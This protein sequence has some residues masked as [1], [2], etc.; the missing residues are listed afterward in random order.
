MKLNYGFNFNDLYSVSG[1]NRLDSKFLEYLKLNDPAAYDL[2]T[3]SRQTNITLIGDSLIKCAKILD[4]FIE[5]L[6]NINN[7]YKLQKNTILDYNKQYIVKRQ[8]IQRYALNKYTESSLTQFDY[9][10]ITKRLEQY[11]KNLS[12]FSTEQIDEVYSKAV[13]NWLKDEENN[14]DNLELA[15]IYAAF[16]IYNNYKSLLFS[17]P[18]KT[19]YDSL[20]EL[21]KN[22]FYIDG[23]NKS[24]I[25]NGI[26][27]N[28]DVISFKKSI[29]QSNYCITCHSN[30]KDTC[31]IG[32]KIGEEYKTNPIGNLLL[33]CPLEQKISEMI[34]LYRDTFIIGSLAVIT[35][36]NPLVAATGERIC[37]DCSKSCILH[38]RESVDVP[39]IETQ[40]LKSILGLDYGFEIYSLLTRWIP[41]AGANFIPSEINKY[42]ILV[43]GS[44]PSG[45]AGSLYLLNKG[46]NISMIE[47]LKVSDLHEDLLSKPIK[48]YNTLI[49]A[50]DNR[51][52]QGFGGVA[53]YGI[54]NRWD[55]TMLIVLRLILQRRSNFELIG[56]TRFGSNIT[57]EQSLNTV[58]FDHILLCA[59]SGKP[60]IPIDIEGISAGN[61]RTASDFLMALQSGGMANDKSTMNMQLLLPAVII[62]SGLTAVDA[63]TELLAYYPI[64]A[65]KF[66]TNYNKAVSNKILT[67]YEKSVSYK[68][69]SH[70]EL[71]NQEDN[72][73][74]LENR[75][76][77]Y[78]NIINYLGGVTIVYR[79][80]INSSPAYRLNHKEL[81]LALEQG[82]RFIE[83]AEVKRIN[84]DELNNCSSIEITKNGIRVNIDSSTI[85]IATGTSPL[86]TSD[87]NL[88]KE[89]E[90]TT[91]LGDMN[92]QYY[93]SV[94]KAIASVKNNIENIDQQ[95]QKEN[96]KTYNVSLKD[97]LKTKVINFIKHN[98]KV[99][100]LIIESQSINA[101]LRPGQYVKL[102][103][104]DCD[105]NEEFEPIAITAAC[106]NNLTPN[107]S[108][109]YVSRNGIKAIPRNID[110][111]ECN[112]IS[113]FLS[114]VGASTKLASKLT[115]TDK[116]ALMGPIGKGFSIPENQ[117]ILVISSGINHLQM[118]GYLDELKTKNNKIFL[119]LSLEN[120]EEDVKLNLL[121]LF[122]NNIII[123]RSNI[124]IS[125]IEKKLYTSENNLTSALQY[126]DLNILELKRIDY[127]FINAKNSYKS[128][129]NI[130]IK[131]YN[132]NLDLD[133]KVFS[134]V[135]VP[136]QCMMQGICGACYSEIIDENGCKE[137]IFT[138]QESFCNLKQQSIEILNAKSN[139]NSLLEKISYNME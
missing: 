95:I 121:P 103:K 32:F 119:I 23:I 39:K 59:G 53:E 108:F 131:N 1:I 107:K 54:T 89:Q 51:E 124:V 50:Y 120:K 73:A 80:N 122:S 105:I 72:L 79:N 69:L 26:K 40:I 94:V 34:L 62:G 102:Q 35:I 84:T 16:R 22:G 45:I 109:L 91:I 87:L 55:K 86:T 19:D 13:A 118:L 127:F 101:N 138:C 74:R 28:S 49:N 96:P 123:C 132:D 135:N 137:I 36:D 93:G 6:F 128:E 4:Q 37:N 61:V 48:N 41:L 64:F 76:P 106:N 58:G 125:S 98:S 60:N 18:N 10:S 33:G 139:S 115:L 5:S 44:G 66:A 104:Y 27:Y 110:I 126:F 129:F 117:N 99:Y 65:K 20:I 29:D 82:V 75:Y 8:F 25:R 24:N 3:S 133:K 47:G 71:F 11:I 67:Q 42:K 70:A 52:S 134:P 31:R 77:S 114:V 81:E 21:N 7:S 57:F 2:L 30:K 15:A 78:V 112:Y 17:K 43:V 68:I 90:R 88:E 100:E 113:F 97:F 85:L 111:K 116:I 130:Y 136:M 14:K 12:S 9:N 56:N 83:C 63:A 46:Y 92:K 38:S